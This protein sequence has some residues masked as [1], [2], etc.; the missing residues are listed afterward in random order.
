MRILCSS[1]KNNCTSCS[2]SGRRAGTSAAWHFARVRT[3]GVKVWCRILGEWLVKELKFPKELADEVALKAI[4]GGARDHVW[5]HAYQYS[6]ALLRGVAWHRGRVRHWREA[7]HIAQFD[8]RAAEGLAARGLAREVRPSRR[9][10]LAALCT[11]CGHSTGPPT[12]RRSATTLSFKCTTRKHPLS[13]RS[14]SLDI[15]RL[16]A[17]WPATRIQNSDSLRSARAPPAT[18]APLRASASIGGPWYGPGGLAPQKFYLLYW[19]GGGVAPLPKF[20]SGYI[21]DTWL[22]QPNLHCFICTAAYCTEN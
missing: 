13:T 20:W 2:E 6:G 1:V 17:Q 18:T 15:P 21:I 4:R 3:G 12:P 22:D 19:G 7:I 8:P 9:R 10:R 14:H 16:S 11:S 5:A